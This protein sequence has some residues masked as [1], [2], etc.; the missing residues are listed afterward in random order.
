MFKLLY[1]KCTLYAVLREQKHLE[2][3]G[4]LHFHS[5]AECLSNKLIQLKTKNILKSHMD[6]S[7][8]VLLLPS[9]IFMSLKMQLC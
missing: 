7:V 1:F 8:L 4:F 2:I 5:N 9:H 6:R 3:K